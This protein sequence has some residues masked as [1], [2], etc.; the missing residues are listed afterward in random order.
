MKT[1]TGTIISA[2]LASGVSIRVRISIIY[3]K[4]I[5][6]S[7]L[8]SR[9]VTVLTKWGDTLIKKKIIIIL[10]YKEIQRDR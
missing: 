9:I 8:M 6:Y 2:L 5:I 7:T 4:K 3:N 1:E 10:I